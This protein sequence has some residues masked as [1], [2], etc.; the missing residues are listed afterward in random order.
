MIS[1]LR[2]ETVGPDRI[3]R[4][5]FIGP[6]GH[7]IR[8]SLDLGKAEEIGRIRGAVDPAPNPEPETRGL[9]IRLRAAVGGFLNP[10]YF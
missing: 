8:A 4:G 6:G 3:W 5:H 9:L 1:S 10:E 7:S 2:S